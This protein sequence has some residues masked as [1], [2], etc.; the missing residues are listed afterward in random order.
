[1]PHTH[2]PLSTTERAERRAQDRELSRRAVTE[3]RSSAGWQR[4]LSLRR[5]FRAYSPAN[6]FLI[7]MQRP[8][9]THVA[10]FRKWL[11]LGYAVKRGECA[12]KIWA[13]VPPSRKRLE[14]WRSEG[15]DPASEPTTYFKLVPVFDTGQVAPLPPPA[16]PMSLEE[17][18]P[19]RVLTGTELADRLP[20][21]IAFAESI[22]SDV[23]FEPMVAREGYYRF[24]DRHIGIRQDRAP[25]AQAKTLVH[26]LAH[27]LLRAERKAGD[28]RLS[29][30]VEELVVESVAFTVCGALG[31]DTSDYSIPYL[32]S[33]DSE[34]D[35]A[36]IE[37][38][39]TLIDRLAARIEVGLA[40]GQRDSTSADVQAA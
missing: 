31:V 18:S 25:N 7:A 40:D 38:T 36:A 8:D 16:E 33:W 37:R 26:E 28:P 9:A 1:M 6:Q 23:A 24:S 27:A 22:G 19:A 13:P 34:G 11:S 5:R 20:G 12:I 2:T 14:R 17:D 4:W 29:P 30:A 35:L 3:L 32:A 21:L 39:A 10:G 15:A